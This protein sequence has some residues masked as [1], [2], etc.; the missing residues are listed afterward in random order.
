MSEVLLYEPRITGLSARAAEIACCV[1]DVL[2][3]RCSPQSGVSEAAAF[4]REWAASTADTAHLDNA[5]F[6][7]VARRY[8]LSPDE[9]DLLLLAGLPDEHEGIATTFRSIHP[10]GE[11]HPTL[12]L[13]ALLLGGRGA[14]RA[15]V[16]DIV[17]G[18]AAV[19]AGLLAAS[20]AGTFF[21]RSLT[22]A[23]GLWDALHGFDGWPGD[24]SRVAVGP[25]PPG[26]DGWLAAKTVGA[27]VRLLRKDTRG[28]VLIASD[29]DV[30]SRARAAALAAAAGRPLVAAL[31][32]AGDK[33]R[34]ALLAV[35]AAARDA[36]PM[37]VVASHPH[38][39]ADTP[40]PS[41][42]LAA[43][44]PGALVVC[45]PPGTVR[46][47][48]DR[49]VLALSADPV[50]ADDQLAAW[51]AAV[52][53]LAEHA[54]AL[55]A[56]HPLDPAIT[57]QLGVDARAQ[58]RELALAD[59]SALVRSRAAASL[60]SGVR[61]ITPAVP[62]S[63]VVLPT[64]SAQQLRAAIT[65]LDLQHVVLEDW[66][67]RD[68]A[69]AARGVRLL[70]TGPAGTGKSLAAAAVATA[71]QTDLLVVDLARVVSKW[72]G[73]TEKNL[74]AAF[75]AAERTQAVLLL[76]EADALFATRTEIADAHDRY[77]NLETA[78]L[79]ERLDRFEGL[80]ILTTNLRANIDAAFIRRL[81]FVVEFPLPDQSARIDL[82]TRHLPV[83][84]L[85]EDIDLDALSRL[86]PVPGAWIRNTAVA[87]AF[88]A[89]AGGSAIS[90]DHLV[91][92]MRREYAKAS[93][94]FPGVPPRRRHD[95]V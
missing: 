5:P 72:L 2:L 77:A 94:P 20:G 31:A 29:D 85:G 55:A 12:G 34:I 11:P 35:H 9:C 70:L 25:P 3:A 21:E 32:P 44:V 87:S 50:T 81:D 89:A 92:A 68:R 76:D 48:A 49:A 54:A 41:E 78:Y 58:N 74:A 27:A 63:D 47:A 33:Y 83:T 61:V 24:L 64:E 46:P 8:R 16:R 65:R 60:P 90:Q 17:T 86:Y 57:A 36:L 23:G 43:D 7:A 93:L 75:A 1:A 6:D 4:L 62:W 38:A 28:V 88:A 59:V 71:A 15:R 84:R 95:P 18:S 53:G 26:L 82:W 45:A 73:E 14:D 51:T 56:R 10:Q 39:P 13:A 69:H 30:V 80:A 22:L 67:M 66:Q 52:P 40:A 37:L 79:L 42:T 19:C 91:D